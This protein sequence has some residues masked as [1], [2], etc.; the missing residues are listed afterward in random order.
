MVIWQGVVGWAVLY[1]AL[2]ALF[3][4]AIAVSI[5]NQAATSGKIGAIVFFGLFI[6]L[7]VLGLVQAFRRRSRLEISSE[8]IMYVNYRDDSL[9]LDRESDGPLRLYNAGG[10]VPPLWRLANR[11]GT[12][13]LPVNRYRRSRLTRL[14]ATKGWEFAR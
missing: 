4:L 10:K 9:A 11:D 13:K 5:P 7:F 2:I 3:A 14:C 12:V 8:R 6:A 1:C